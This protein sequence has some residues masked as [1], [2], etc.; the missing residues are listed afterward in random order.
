MKII[1]DSALRDQ[2]LNDDPKVFENVLPSLA[3]YQALLQIKGI[4]EVKE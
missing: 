3:A 1:S 2:F 4:L